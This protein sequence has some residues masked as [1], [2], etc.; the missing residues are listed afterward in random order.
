MPLIFALRYDIY[1]T[2]AMLF[3]AARCALL[4][5]RCPRRYADAA[6]RAFDAPSVICR[7]DVYVYAATTYALLPLLMIAE[8]YDYAAFY[9]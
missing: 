3:A 5:E 1:A 9:A 2:R 6:Q 7:S 4:L 8:G